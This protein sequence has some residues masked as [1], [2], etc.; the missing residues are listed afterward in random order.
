MRS[1]VDIYIDR[2]SYCGRRCTLYFTRLPWPGR[3]RPPPPPLR[4]FP[5]IAS[6]ASPPPLP[7]A[8][9]VSSMLVRAGFI[10]QLHPRL[11]CSCVRTPCHVSLS[12]CPLLSFAVALSLS[13]HLSSGCPPVSYCS[14]H[15]SSINTEMSVRPISHS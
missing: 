14:F 9:P 4:R 1:G 13:S 7:R 5:G 2:C 6:P 15:A 10:C 11:S 8:L 3:R 12:L